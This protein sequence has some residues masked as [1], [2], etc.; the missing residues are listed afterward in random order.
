LSCEEFSSRY[1]NINAVAAIGNPLR[2]LST[3]AELG[4]DPV[5]NS[6]PDHSGFDVQDL[7]FDN[8][9][10]V[11]CTEKDAVKIR[12]LPE[13]PDNIWYLEIDVELD[14]V[15]GRSA[16][17]KLAALLSAHGVRKT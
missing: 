12:E 9:W 17:D 3:L 14:P 5:M 11:V 2:F 10:P 16:E 6:L 4:F 1:P 8:A 13:V 15:A 7:A